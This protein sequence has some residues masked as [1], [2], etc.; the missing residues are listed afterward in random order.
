MNAKFKS[1]VR[2]ANN[3]TPEEV[4]KKIREHFQAKIEGFEYCNSIPDAAM[5]KKLTLH[6]SF[7]HPNVTEKEVT[8]TLME[9]QGIYFLIELLP[10][11]ES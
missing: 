8:Q 11:R 6:F 3:K 7:D 1:S 2:I 5:K 10:V 4:M 9:I